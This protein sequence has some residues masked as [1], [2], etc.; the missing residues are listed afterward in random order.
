LIK[1]FKLVMLLHDTGKP[2]CKKSKPK[3][4]LW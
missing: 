2:K 4:R 3:N 1:L